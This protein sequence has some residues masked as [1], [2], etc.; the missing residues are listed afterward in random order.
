MKSAALG[1]VG[2]VVSCSGGVDCVA[3][4]CPAPF[5]ITITVTSATS[6]AAITGAVVATSSPSNA[7]FPCGAGSCLVSGYAGTYVLDISA[8]GF[9]TSHRSVVVPGSAPAKCG[10]STTETQHLDVALV[11]AP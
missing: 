7:S 10:C 8:P 9:Q 2:L 4:P 6:G 5:A 11:P 1:L 3:L